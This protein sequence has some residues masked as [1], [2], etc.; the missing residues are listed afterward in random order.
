MGMWDSVSDLAE[1][2]GAVDFDHP[3]TIS[4]DDWTI[5][6]APDAYAPSVRHSDTDDVEI[7]GD[8]WTALD[9]L[10]GQYGY[11][12]AVMHQS[13][14]V[15]PNVMRAMLDVLDDEPAAVFVMAVVD[16]DDDGEPAGWAVLYR[17]AQ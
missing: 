15:G 9:G 13:E 14:L 1:K 12:G 5:T 11:S 2:V 10:T 16:S 7:D 17:A 8:G 6:D 3:F 4:R